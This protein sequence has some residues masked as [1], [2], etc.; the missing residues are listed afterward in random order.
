MYY[1][2]TQ[3]SIRVTVLH[4]HA[5]FEIDGEQS[6]EKDPRIVTE[7][8][9]TISE[10]LSH[11]HHS[12]HA[13]CVNV[14]N[15]LVAIKSIIE[16][17]ASISTVAIVSSDVAEDYYPFKVLS[18]GSEILRKSTKDDWGGIF[19]ANTEVLTAHFYTK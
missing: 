2:Q 16:L 10:D 12:V 19:R 18:D 5:L 1:G 17:T 4:R 8:L 9:F 15:Y 11:D 13:C 3:A 6:T 14:A 7:D